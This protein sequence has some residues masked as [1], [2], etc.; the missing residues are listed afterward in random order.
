MKIL[1]FKILL[2]A[3]SILLS[4][5]QLFSQEI[6][7]RPTPPRLV[8]DFT[9]TLSREQANQL[10]RKLVQFN[11]QTSN[12]IAVVLVKSL[13]GIALSDFAYSIGEKWKVGQQEFNNGIVILVKPKTGREKGRAF[14][15]TGYGLEGA[16][17]DGTTK[18]IVE[19]EMIPYFKN[20]DYYG[21][22]N[23]ACLVLM[24]L[25]AGEFSSDEYAKTT[26]QG[27]PIGR[28]VPFI[29]L[30]II[31]IFMRS[32]RARSHSVGAG[33]PFWTALWLGSS[34]MGGSS[35]GSW[36]NF[37]SGSGGFGGGGGFGGFGGGSFGGGGAGGSW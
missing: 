25:A 9:G 29:I 1:N 6:P 30:I 2:I 7:E 10:E 36:N 23:K 24:P 14:I 16:I 32:S 27:S 21:G 11:N 34:M 33:I 22:I 28:I 19:N 18:L 35:Q 26:S 15:A 20:G 5:P 13:N 8:N 3:L 12:Q 31:F 4:V 37:S 17:P